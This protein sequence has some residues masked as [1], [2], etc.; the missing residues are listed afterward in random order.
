MPVS[1]FF[2]DANLMALFLV[3]NHP[4][5]TDFIYSAPCHKETVLAAIIWSSGSTCMKEE[6]HTKESQALRPLI[7]PWLSVTPFS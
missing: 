1:L 5:K 3:V 2:L 6:P 7:C 4:L